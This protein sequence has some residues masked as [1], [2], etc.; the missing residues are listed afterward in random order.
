[1]FLASAFST[2]GSDW[3]LLAGRPLWPPLEVSAL[4]AH[5]TTTEV[6]QHAR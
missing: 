3:Q 5:T 6:L 4:S 1:M 2:G